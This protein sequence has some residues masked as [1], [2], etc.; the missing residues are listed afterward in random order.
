MTQE[1]HARY[2]GWSAGIIKV[3]IPGKRHPDKENRW[4]K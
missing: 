4:I 1:R 2:D 3:R